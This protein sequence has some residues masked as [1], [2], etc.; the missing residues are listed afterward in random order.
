MYTRQRQNNRQRHGVNV[1]I[2]SLTS[3]RLKADDRQQWCGECSRARTASLA[4]AS[5][6][7]RICSI[8]IIA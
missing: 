5:I 6:Q 7:S 3:Q 4:R 8:L 1:S 2:R